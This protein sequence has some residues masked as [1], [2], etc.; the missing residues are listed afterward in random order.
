MAPTIESRMAI[1]TN[2]PPAWPMLRNAT[3]PP[4]G[5]RKQPPTPRPP[6]AA[7]GARPRPSQVP[8]RGPRAP[9]PQEPR[10]P[11][12]PQAQDLYPRERLLPPRA[13][14]HAGIF[15]QRHRRDQG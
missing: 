14:R 8:A 6:E 13:Q 4:P 15:H 5:I 7:W 2:A 12:D 11:Q 9:P 1:E 3:R 10:P